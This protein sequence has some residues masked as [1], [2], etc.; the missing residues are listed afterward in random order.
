MATKKIVLCVDGTS[1]LLSKD[2]TDALGM[3][4]EFDEFF[5][6]N[7]HHDMLPRTDER[8]VALIEQL[9]GSALLRSKSFDTSGFEIGEVECGRPYYI[10]G[11]DWETERICYQDEI[12]W[13]TA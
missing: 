13:H 11:F 2:A 3:T 7:G 9:D 10:Q 6:K 4:K 5:M 8:L 1:F 12:E